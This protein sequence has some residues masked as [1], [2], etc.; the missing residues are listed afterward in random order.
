MNNPHYIILNKSNDHNN[1]VNVNLSF[2][3]LYMLRAILS[4]IFFCFTFS[5]FSKTP[6]EYQKSYQEFIYSGNYKD[7]FNVAVEYYNEHH[8]TDACYRLAECFYRGIG[9]EQNAEAAKKF[10]KAVYES[11]D[12]T[13]NSPI[14]L[15]QQ[16]GYCTRMYVS[17]KCLSYLTSNS[18]VPQEEYTPYFKAI[19][20]ADDPYSLFVIGSAYHFGVF[21][22]VN[23]DKGIS[24]LSR[25][26]KYN[27][28]AA[29]SLLGMIYDEKGDEDK[30]YEYYYRAANTP[31]Y[32]LENSTGNEYFVNPNS[33]ENPVV[34]QYRDSALYSLGYMLFDLNSHE[35]SSFYLNQISNTSD[36][37]YVMKACQSNICS[38][39][40]DK[41]L[42]WADI[43]SSIEPTNGLIYF[44]KGLTYYQ[45]NKFE[46]CFSMIDKA[47]SLG[48]Q[49]AVAFKNNYLK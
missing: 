45:L 10:Y 18:P 11:P 42:Y 32:R 12:V 15:R 1:S 41:A 38:Q 39:N 5:L 48:N 27:S 23:C 25:A 20:I 28:I 17:L 43:A 13:V 14:D 49:D 34:I 4:I 29:L 21:G 22:E 2:N 31:I 35:E 40:Y 6:N 19:E 47:I 16:Y 26:A 44:Y 46:D 3:K 24:Y 33:E 36:I 9:T 8:I 37:R 30:A 7:A